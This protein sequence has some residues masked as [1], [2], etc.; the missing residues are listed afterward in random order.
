MPRKHAALIRQIHARRI[1]EINDRH[2]VAHRDLLRTE[3]L[4]DRF[5]IP[6]PGLDSRVVGNN[7]TLAAL[8]L[9]DHRHDR[10]RRGRAVI[11]VIGDKQAD[12]LNE[13]VFVEQ[14]ADSFAGRQLALLVD[15]VDLLRTAAEF[16]VL[17]KAQVVVGEVSQGEAD[18]QMISFVVNDE[19]RHHTAAGGHICQF[20]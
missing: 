18:W 9:A 15:L 2:A 14:Q 13:G 17:F 20:G 12:L 3:D 1:D 5:G 16:K 7:N 19:R 8:D 11:L 4:F 6:R 10:R